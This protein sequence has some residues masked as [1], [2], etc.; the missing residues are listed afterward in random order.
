MNEDFYKEQRT[1]LANE[2]WF[3]KSKRLYMSAKAR[4]RKIADLDYEH[5]GIDRETTKTKFNY[6]RIK[7]EE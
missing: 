4:V 1:R 2:F 7:T 3:L 5:C 6:Y